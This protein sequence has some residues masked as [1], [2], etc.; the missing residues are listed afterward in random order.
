MLESGHLTQKVLLI[1]QAEVDHPGW[2]LCGELLAQQEQVVHAAVSPGSGLE[3]AAPATQANRMQPVLGD[4]DLLEGGQ[5]EQLQAPLS[6]HLHAGVVAHVQP[7]QLL[8]PCQR[9]W[10]PAP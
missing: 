1:E 8:G 4:V 3:L 2:A 7:L 10:N 5:V 6:I 9:A